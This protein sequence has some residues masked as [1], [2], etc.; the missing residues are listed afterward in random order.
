MN[1]AMALEMAADSHPDRIT[2][3]SGNA[4]MSCGELQAAVLRH[5]NLMSC[6]LGTVE[7]DGATAAEELQARVR[8]RLRSSRVPAAIL[9]RDQLPH[10]EMSR[11]LRRVVQQEFQE[12]APRSH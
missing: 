2:A 11:I 10:N 1:I 9:F 4:R 3:T 12:S 8:D 7:F 5:E 6:I